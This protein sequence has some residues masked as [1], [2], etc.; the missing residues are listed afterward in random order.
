MCF[1]VIEIPVG[2]FLFSRFFGSFGKEPEGSVDELLFRQ[3]EGLVLVRFDI[4]STMI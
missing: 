1:D 3:V 2:G 4:P